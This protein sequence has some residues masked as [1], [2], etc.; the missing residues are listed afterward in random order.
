MILKLEDAFQKFRSAGRQG[1]A[2]FVR[3]C[4]QI[5]IA[6]AINMTFLEFIASLV[7]F[8]PRAA[9]CN[10]AGKALPF[11]ALELRHPP[12]ATVSLDSHQMR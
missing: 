10:I 2:T 5:A 6:I 4:D 1:K 8:G 9:A 7:A 11:D 12:P 3:G